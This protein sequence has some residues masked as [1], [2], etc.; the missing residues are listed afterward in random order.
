[1][2]LNRREIG[3][4]IGTIGLTCLFTGGVFFLYLSQWSFTAWSTIAVYDKMVA[5]VGRG[6]ITEIRTGGQTGTT[7]GFGPLYIRVSRDR[8]VKAGHL[9]EADAGTLPELER[10]DDTDFHGN[11]T[12]RY[13]GGRT[14]I[15]FEPQGLT[16]VNLTADTPIEFSSKP[17]GPFYKLPIT[18][19][20]LVELFGQPNKWKKSGR[21]AI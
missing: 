4:L 17:S 11:V 16:F 15:V 1:M 19:K 21:P 13:M 12:I 5:Q 20:Q 10:T 7:G 14:M 3:I 6:G 8:I 18:K 2:S 9:K